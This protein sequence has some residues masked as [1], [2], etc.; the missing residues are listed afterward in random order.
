MDYKLN[1][2]TAVLLKQLSSFSQSVIVWRFISQRR[3]F[4]Y[5][6]IFD[7]IN[8]WLKN[9]EFY[10]YKRQIEKLDANRTTVD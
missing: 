3:F 8:G 1:Y 2:S 7:S 5:L 10:D 4:K 6:E 9:T